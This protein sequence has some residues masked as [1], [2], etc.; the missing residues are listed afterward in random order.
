MT[1]REEYLAN[2]PFTPVFGKVPPYL[3]GREQL[4]EDILAAFE[5]PDNSPD[6]CTLFVGARGTGKTALLTYLA[7]EAQRMGW[8][9]ADVTASPD[10]LEDIWQ[11]STAASSHLLPEPPRRTLTGI[12]VSALGNLSWKS[13]DPVEANWR[14]NMTELIEQLDKT[15][16][17]LLITV[18][19]VDPSL[20]D[21]TTLVTTYQHFVRENRR[22]VLLMAGLPHHVSTLLSGKSTSFLR[23]AARRDLGSIP[24]FEVRDA[25]RLTAQQGGKDI[26][27]DALTAAV[28]SID[29]FPFMFQLVGYRSWNYAQNRAIIEL[30][31]VVQGIDAARAEL[32]SRVLDATMAEL[33]PAD[34]RF[35]KAMAQDEGMTRQADLKDRLGK[36]SGHISTYKK[37]L[38]EAG[39]IEEPF[40]GMLAFALPGLR[41]YLI[42]R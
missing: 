35:L 10:M 14:T 6:R 3:A 22:I 12:G 32:T 21:M 33:S 7:N 40:R 42:N 23:R 30:G 15:K 26:A 41:D 4:I 28:A 39:T 16:T 20:E 31:D 34:V 37:R 11:R 1:N 27:E 2:N 17:G 24:D 29:G 18:D 36:T 8:V 38:L 19:E 5:H 9:T 13:N 25:F